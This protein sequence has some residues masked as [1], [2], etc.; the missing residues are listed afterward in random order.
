MSVFLDHELELEYR[1]SYTQAGMLDS[2]HIAPMPANRRRAAPVD[3]IDEALHDDVG[4]REQGDDWLLSVISIR[5]RKSCFL[6]PAEV[7]QAKLNHLL[8]LDWQ[9]GLAVRVPSMLRKELLKL[10][11]DAAGHCAPNTIVQ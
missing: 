6:A 4:P 11:L 5:D 3:D 2:L 1:L 10:G 8:P 9:A 7:S